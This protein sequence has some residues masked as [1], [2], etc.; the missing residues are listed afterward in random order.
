MVDLLIVEAR[1]LTRRLNLFAAEDSRL[2][3]WP[4]RSGPFPRWLKAM[5]PPL[6]SFANT[7][8]GGVVGEVR[9]EPFLDRAN[10]FA[11]AA[12]IVNDLI[13]I[14]LADSKIFR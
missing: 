13:A 9:P 1:V 8:S 4:M 3:T 14:D 7:R 6:V 5:P 2:Y 12:S 11:P 10:R